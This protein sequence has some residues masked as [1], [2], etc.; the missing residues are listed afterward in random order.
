MD[1]LQ[2]LIV[3]SNVVTVVLGG[4]VTMLAVRAYSRT[5]STPLRALAV[6]FGCITAGSIVSGLLHQVGFVTL[7]GGVAVQNVFV[8]AGFTFV[9]IALFERGPREGRHPVST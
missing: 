5:E 3:A 1:P 8:A 9:A 2:L 4:L 7:L 6:G